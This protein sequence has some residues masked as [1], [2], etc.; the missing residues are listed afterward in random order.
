M[1]TLIRAEL[2]KLASTRTTRLLVLGGLA[3]AALLGTVT[4]TT[5][6]EEASAALGSAESMAN[7]VGVSAM[8]GFF[9]LILGVLGMAGEYQHRTITQTF[10]SVPVRGRVMAAKLA[11]ITTA[12][13]VTATAMMATALVAAL[14]HV[15][16]EGA[17]IHL[18]NAEVGRAA[19]GTLLAG[20]LFGIAGTSLGA[21]LRSQ[22]AAVVAVAAWVA[23]GEGVLALVLGPDIARWLPGGVA[24]AL[25]ASGVHA[26]PLWAATLVL[27]GYCTAGVVAATRL[28][29]RRDVA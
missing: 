26:L 11:A 3:V 8:P 16:A 2:L 23:I 17:G 4:A 25:A 5:A 18:V 10:L 1:N 15:W 6:G 21:L 22:I 29:L 14:P 27:T 12:G 28:T 24:S 9:M 13:V 20:A 19:L 7:I